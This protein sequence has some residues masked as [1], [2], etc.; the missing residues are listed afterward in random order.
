MLATTIRLRGTA[1][2]AATAS[3]TSTS[4]ALLIRFS[5]TPVPRNGHP[6]PKP[7]EADHSR[8]FR[9][10][11]AR[12]VCAERYQDRVKLPSE[13]REVWSAHGTPVRPRPSGEPDVIQP[14]RSELTRYL[15]TETV[16]GSILLVAAAVAVIWAN[17]PWADA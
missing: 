14:L 16:G 13:R 12:G 15:R 8:R 4:G 2:F 5:C 11:P 3:S 10:N 9:G 7:Q 1:S 6:P 17:S